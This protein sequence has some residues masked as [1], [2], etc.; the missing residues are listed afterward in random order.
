MKT[1]IKE[2]TDN[3]NCLCNP[4]LCGENCACGSSKQYERRGLMTSL[5]LN[6][7]IKKM[8]QDATKTKI[9]PTH[10]FRILLKSF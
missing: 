7:L 6:F 10:C 2:T 5:P 8:Q 4:C 3:L 9:L 1:T